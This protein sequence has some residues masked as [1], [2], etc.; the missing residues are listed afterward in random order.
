MDDAMTI[1]E[2]AER[3]GEPVTHRLNKKYEKYLA[4]LSRT[5]MVEVWKKHIAVFPLIADVKKDDGT[6]SRKELYFESWVD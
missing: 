2:F 3:L 1:E 4:F 5:D 6:D